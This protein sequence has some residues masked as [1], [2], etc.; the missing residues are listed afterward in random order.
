[1]APRARILEWNQEQQLKRTEDAAFYLNCVVDDR[2]PGG[3]HWDGEIY[4]IP[5]II[6]RWQFSEQIR[7]NEEDRRYYESVMGN[8]KGVEL[9]RDLN[10]KRGSR[11]ELFGSRL[12]V[13]TW[14]TNETGQVVED[15][16]L[17]AN[18]IRKIMV[19]NYSH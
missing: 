16:I 11:L 1:M 6:R 12:P 2:G 14:R 19:P 17:N 4:H 18:L 3:P 15:V 8:V 7:E 10:L 5:V 13:N 9:I